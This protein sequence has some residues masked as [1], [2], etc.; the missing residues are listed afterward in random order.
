MNFHPMQHGFWFVLLFW[1][2]VFAG[3]P[4]AVLLAVLATSLYL[5][6]HVLNIFRY[7]SAPTTPKQ[8]RQNGQSYAVVTG[9]SS[10]IGKDLAKELGRKG[11]DLVLV[12]RTEK[13][14]VALKEEYEKEYGV[15]VEYIAMDLADA[16]APQKLMD[17]L[18]EKGLLDKVGVLVNNAGFGG[19]G[20]FQDQDEQSVQQMIQLNVLN[21]TMIT[22]KMIPHLLA[23]NCGYVMNVSSIFGLLHTP[24]ETV[25]ASTKNYV[26]AFTLG[27]EH[28]L[29]PTGVNV[30]VL[31]PGATVTEFAEVSGLNKSLIFNLPKWPGTNLTMMTH[32]SKFVAKGGVRG[33]FNGDVHIFPGFETEPM[34]RLLSTGFPHRVLM[35][36]LDT[37]LSEPPK[38]F[39]RWVASFEAKMA[40]KSVKSGSSWRSFFG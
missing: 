1:A 18:G 24:M 12:A 35:V 2:L 37:A 32:T 17:A 30:C 5:L 36:F 3:K 10:G 15:D 29:Q 33:M 9:A 7:K 31:A 27:L 16:D 26:T 28:E 14:L 4:L 23:K 19:N 38:F 13:K 21:L 22:R 11:L 6:S 25:Y 40:N 20:L 39:K 34:I 8:L